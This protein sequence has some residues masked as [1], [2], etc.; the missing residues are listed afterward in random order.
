MAT[1]DIIDVDG[2]TVIGQRGSFVSPGVASSTGSGPSPGLNGTVDTEG[3]G[4]AGYY[5]AGEDGENNP[6]SGGRAIPIEE[7]LYAIFESPDND[8]WM[9]SS[10]GGGTTGS[11]AD[12]APGR[13]GRFIVNLSDDGY[14][15]PGL[16]IAPAGSEDGGGAA[17]AC[18]VLIAKRFLPMTEGTIYSARGGTPTDLGGRGGKG[19]VIRISLDPYPY[20]DRFY[21]DS[22]TGSVDML[23]VP[24]VGVRIVAIDGVR[25]SPQPAIPVA[26]IMSLL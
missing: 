19:L 25:V 22:E 20:D 10:G 7:I 1:T 11:A 9:G 3:G 12:G 6:G 8:S 24:G 2:V 13:D 15:P 26:G 4:G 16:T 18:I 17:G 23:F 5:T 14:R 21:V